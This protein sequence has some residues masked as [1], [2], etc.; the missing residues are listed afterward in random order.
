MDEYAATNP[1]VAL[2]DPRQAK[3]GSPLYEAFLLLAF[4]YLFAVSGRRII[5]VFVNRFVYLHAGVFD[6]FLA[7]ADFLQLRP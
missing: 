5:L 7:L 6:C 2:L 1:A 4:L 3:S